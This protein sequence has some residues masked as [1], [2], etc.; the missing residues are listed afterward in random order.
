[1]ILF[2]SAEYKS[3]INSRFLGESLDSLLSSVLPTL[4]KSRSDWAEVAG[5]I[6]PESTWAQ[7]FP[8]KSFHPDLNWPAGQGG[9][10][11]VRLGFVLF[12]PT[13]CTGA[14]QKYPD[15]T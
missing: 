11:Q 2:C 4:L 3:S 9:S 12:C 8:I 10:P 6:Y 5:Y 13:L 15:S 1:M 7:C 14:V